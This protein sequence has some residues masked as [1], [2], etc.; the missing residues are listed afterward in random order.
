MR[1]GDLAL[2]ALV[3]HPI[4]PGAP[5]AAWPAQLRIA[6]QRTTGQPYGWDAGAV[7]DETG[8]PTLV[9]DAV[10]TGPVW[11]DAVCDF[12]ALEIDDGQPDDLGLFPARRLALSLANRAGQWSTWTDA[13]RAAAFPIGTPLDVWCRYAGEDRWLFA[14]YV[15]EWSQVGDRVEIVAFDGYSDLA[16]DWGAPWTPGS[17]GQRPLAR[18]RAIATAARWPGTVTGDVGHTDLLTAQVDADRSPLEA[19]QVA[20]LSDGGIVVGDVDGKLVVRDRYWR[21]G[22]TDQPRVWTFTDNACDIDAAVVWDADWGANDTAVANEVR[23]TNIAD[24]TVVATTGATRPVRLTHPDPDVWPTTAVGQT[25]AD[26]LLDQ[27]TVAGWRLNSFALH[28]RD[29]HQPVLWDAGTDLRRGD[30]MHWISDTFDAEGSPLR[31]QLDTIVAG[32]RHEITPTDWLTTVTGT[33]A[34]ASLITLL[35]D[36][37]HLWDDPAPSNVWS[38]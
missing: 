32:V 29:P 36:D 17:A 1:T 6:V 22:R 8:D 28:L 35:W 9:W 12:E 38:A 3:P 7:W 23:L 14:G 20:V 33:R 19:M 13:G 26:F 30:R 24:A 37:G 27:A 10:A 11:V 16:G 34:V 25:L 5:V 4:P 18:V 15:A 21:N 31:L 2:P